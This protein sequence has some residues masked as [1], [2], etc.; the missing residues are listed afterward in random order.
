[1]VHGVTRQ[2]FQNHFSRTMVESSES[3]LLTEVRL[4]VVGSRNFQPVVRMG[5]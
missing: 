2:V 3:K 5:D 4:F 1:M